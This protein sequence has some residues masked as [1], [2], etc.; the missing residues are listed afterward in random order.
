[1]IQIRVLDDAIFRST[2]DHNGLITTMLQKITIGPVNQTTSIFWRF[3]M[4]FIIRHFNHFLPIHKE[5]ITKVLIAL[6]AFLTN[7]RA[8]FV[9]GSK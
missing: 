2:L 3:I 5:I 7:H 6:Y 4:N 9:L 1:M 8:T